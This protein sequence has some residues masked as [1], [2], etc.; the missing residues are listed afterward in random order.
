MPIASRITDMFGCRFPL[1]HAGMGGVAT[2]D[3]AIAVARAGG[4]GML[5]GIIGREALSSQLDAASADAPIGVNFLV[6]FLDRG[7]VAEAAA[8]SPLVEFFWAMRL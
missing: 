2:P 5:S 1:Q 7:A 8:R 3:L 4:I 6:P